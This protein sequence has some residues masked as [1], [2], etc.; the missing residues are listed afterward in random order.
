MSFSTFVPS[1]PL[2]AQGPTKPQISSRSPYSPQHP[3]PAV[4]RRHTPRCVAIPIDVVEDNFETEV[5][6]SEVPVLVDFYATWCGPC[7]LIS[8][9]MDWAATEFEGKLK[10][11]KIDTEQNKSFVDKYDIRGLPTLA[12]FKG[13]EAYGIKE[14][15]MGQNLLEKYLMEYAPEVL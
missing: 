11:A 8:P 5:L 7:K 2:R 12:I 1:L 4:L 3:R 9:V 13:G 10:V 6:K 14:G 15:A